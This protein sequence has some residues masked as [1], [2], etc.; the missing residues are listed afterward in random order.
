MKRAQC[1]RQSL[2]LVSIFTVTLAMGISSGSAW[3][4]GGGTGNSCPSQ[5]LTQTAG[6]RSE[7]EAR[8]KCDLTGNLWRVTSCCEIVPID[9]QTIEWRNCV[10]EAEVEP[11]PANCNPPTTFF[12]DE[13]GR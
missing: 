13:S 12:R 6:G 3:A 2:V 10:V 8:Y 7:C 4:T 11:L 9:C 1:D 5:T